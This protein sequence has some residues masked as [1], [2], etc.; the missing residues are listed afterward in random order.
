MRLNA[1]LTNK[2]D[3]SSYALAMCKKLLGSHFIFVLGVVTVVSLSIMERPSYLIMV[4]VQGVVNN[5]QEYGEATDVSNVLENANRLSPREEVP[6]KKL[7]EET[8]VAAQPDVTMAEDTKHTHSFGIR[9][10]TLSHLK[11]L[12]VFPKLVHVNWPD[13]NVINK[14][15]A[16]ITHG[17]KRIRDQNPDWQVLLHDD[18]DIIEMIKNFQ[19]PASG[20]KEG[21]EWFPESMRTQLLNGHIIE[22]TDAFRLMVMYEQGGLYT[23]ID[24]VANI[25]LAEVIDIEQTKLVVPTYFDV[26]FAQDLFGSAPKNDLMMNILRRQCEKRH[27][28]PRKEGWLKSSNVMDICVTHS[29]SIEEDLFGFDFNSKIGQEIKDG[30]S[31]GE[32]WNETRQLL[33]DHSEGLIL[34]KKEQWCDGLL[35]RPY[36]GCKGVS[37]G[38]LYEHYNM[39]GWK[40]EVNAVWQKTE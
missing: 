27:T 31:E 19:P 23:D 35:V 40:K 13:K 30:K 39:T 37:R 28:Y 20:G 2:A 34:T 15:F 10:E 14:D 36:P 1:S 18:H 3:N 32:W 11:T 29:S 12:G 16:V 22:Q 5:Q 17:I 4:D 7:V 25:P 9:P 24:R 26:N 21:K 38:G 33:H 6:P 8:K